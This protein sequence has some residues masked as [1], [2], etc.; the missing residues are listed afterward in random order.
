ME[1]LRELKAVGNEAGKHALVSL[2]ALPLRDGDARAKTHATQGAFIIIQ[3][4]NI[5]W[6]VLYVPSLFVSGA[7]F[8]F[9]TR[10]L[11]PG[12]A[13]LAHTLEV[14]SKGGHTLTPQLSLSSLLA[15]GLWHSVRQVPS[16]W[17]GY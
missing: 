13:A 17:L 5:A 16:L 10:T 3:S 1:R 15:R 14:C 4:Q 11:A 12:L 2:L 6:T 9:Q 7:L 8:S